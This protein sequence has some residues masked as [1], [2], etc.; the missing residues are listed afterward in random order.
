MEDAAPLFRCIFISMV[1]VL[2]QQGMLAFHLHWDMVSLSNQS[3]LVKTNMGLFKKNI[4]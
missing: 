4:Q 2:L 1:T 3:L